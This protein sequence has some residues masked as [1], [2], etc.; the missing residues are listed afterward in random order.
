MVTQLVEHERIHTTLPKA[1]ELRRMADQVVGLAKQG[2]FNAK[3]RAESILRTEAS[4][5]K[6][7]DIFG[8]RYAYVC[9]CVLL[10]LNRASGLLTI[11]WLDHTQQCSRGRL[12]ARAQGR[13]PPR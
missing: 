6:L 9:P 13:L 11:Y 3:K 4:V 2:D 10:C 5:T 1:K 12:H 7:F 8:P